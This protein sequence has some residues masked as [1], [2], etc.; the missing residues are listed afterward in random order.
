MPVDA[1]F[2]G[3]DTPGMFLKDLDLRVE[4]L[5]PRRATGTTSPHPRSGTLKQA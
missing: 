1:R 2:H 3:G 5:R 4:E